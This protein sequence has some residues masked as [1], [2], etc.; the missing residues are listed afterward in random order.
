VL[1][2]LPPNLEGGNRHLR[3]VLVWHLNI[4]SL[5]VNAAVDIIVSIRSNV[6]TPV[7]KRQDKLTSA[8]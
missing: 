1:A 8:N 5:A 7:E 3:D 6:G 4:A 2:N